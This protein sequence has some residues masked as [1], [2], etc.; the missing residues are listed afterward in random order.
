MTQPS[1]ELKK[2]RKIAPQDKRYVEVF[3]FQKAS[4]DSIKAL[5]DRPFYVKN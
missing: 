1:K 3:D 2:K 4:A 5:R